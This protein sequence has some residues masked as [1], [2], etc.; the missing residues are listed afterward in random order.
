M[1]NTAGGKLIVYLIGIITILIVKSI[2]LHLVMF[3]FF[4]FVDIYLN[5]LGKLKKLFLVFLPFLITASLLVWLQSEKNWVLVSRLINI[6]LWNVLIFKDFA[7]QDLKDGLAQLHFP[8]LIILTIFFILRY[9]RVI[10]EEINRLIRARKLRGAEIKNKFFNIKEYIILA[11][12]IGS[13]LDRSLKRSDRIYKAMQL[14]GLKS[15]TFVKSKQKL[16]ISWQPIFLTLF[17]SALII[18]L[19][20]GW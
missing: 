15:A 1:K 18:L 3:I 8:N 16:I 4:L 5:L 10:K 9:F 13:S 14:R 12:I 11:Q 20:R 19:D 2:S 17:I 6:I 7:E